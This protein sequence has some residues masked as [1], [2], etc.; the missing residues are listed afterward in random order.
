MTDITLLVFEGGKEQ[1]TAWWDCSRPSWAKI[2]QVATDEQCR[3]E[4]AG[5]KCLFWFPVLEVA[6][7]YGLAPLLGRE[8]SSGEEHCGRVCGRGNCSPQGHQEVRKERKEQNP[9]IPFQGGPPLQGRNCVSAGPV[10]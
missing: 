4:R 5:R 6:V 1:S 9:T 3:E 8:G 10:P 2:R 7:Q